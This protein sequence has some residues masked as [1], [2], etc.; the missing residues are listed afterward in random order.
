MLIC[1]LKE[2]LDFKNM[3]KSPLAG[4][5]NVTRPFVQNLLDNKFKDLNID[6]VDRVM[7]E[8]K[9]N[10]FNQLFFYIPYEIEMEYMK[11]SLY[12][13]SQY[14]VSV[15]FS[16]LVE[17]IDYE[18]VFDIGITKV[19]K[20]RTFALWELSLLSGNLQEWN[21]FISKYDVYLSKYITDKVRDTI[22]AQRGDDKK[23]LLPL[24]IR[25]TLGV[26]I[27]LKGK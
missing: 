12:S 16:P 10:D 7:K 18:K 13:N 8:L 15:R 27:D 25:E 17:S 14:V 22:E 24:E 9:L 21:S 5:A 26:S 11:E 23:H 2:I 6:S 3:K 1:K 20:P 19:E 4:G